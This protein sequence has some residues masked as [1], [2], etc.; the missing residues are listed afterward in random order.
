[1]HAFEYLLISSSLLFTWTNCQQININIGMLIP[2]EDKGSTDTLNF[3]NS[4]GAVVTG[5]N[6][7]KELKI[8][9]PSVVNLTFTWYFSQCD[10]SLTA[11]YAARLIYKDNVAAILGP[12]VSLPPHFLLTKTFRS[13]FGVPQLQLTSTT[14]QNIQ[15]P[16]HSPA[17]QEECSLPLSYILAEFDWVDVAFLFTTAQDINA[18]CGYFADTFETQ[19]NLTEAI[20]PVVIKRMS[21]PSVK[22]FDTIMKTIKG[23]ARII[24]TC[25]ERPVEKRNYMLSAINNEMIS[26][27]GFGSPPFWVGTDG[28]DGEIREAARTI[29]IMDRLVNQTQERLS[30]LQDMANNVRGWPFYCKDC[31]LNG[32]ASTLAIYLADS[33]I[34]YLW[35]L[36]KTYTR[37]GDASQLTNTSEII[38][39]FQAYL[40][41]MPSVTGTS[42]ILNN[43]LRAARFF[44]TQ[45][46]YNDSSTTIWVLRGGIQPVSVLQST[47]TV[48]EFKTLY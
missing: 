38:K 3:A 32:T 13:F 39:N 31:P 1:M 8:Y 12:Q 45:K 23:R 25:F 18:V 35:S 28:R 34:A 48:L 4:A 40:P 43:G 36:N 27:V 19:S 14:G 41:D 29:L 5:I 30:L 2:K 47:F 46:A 15:Q 6:R 17:Q 44:L 9:D 33:V 11:G 22:D 7:A 42:Y 16:F 10:D 37:L 26:S 20:N 24:I 21:N